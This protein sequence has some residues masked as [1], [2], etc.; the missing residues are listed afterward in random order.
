MGHKAGDHV[1]KEVAVRL[2]ETVRETDTVVRIGGDEFIV[3]FTAVDDEAIVVM[4]TEK[5]IENLTRP[6]EIDGEDVTISSSIGVALYPDHG[7]LPD[8]LISKADEA[9]YIVKHRGKNNYA[10]AK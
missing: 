3:I 1:L 8:E 4:M 5:I 7:D 6:I 9:M 2:T 10:I